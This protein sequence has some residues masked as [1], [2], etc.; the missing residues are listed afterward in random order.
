MEPTQIASD[1]CIRGQI[2]RSLSLQKSQ[3]NGSIEQPS[4]RLSKDI[5]EL[6]ASGLAGD[7]PFGGKKL[8]KL[9]T[10]QKKQHYGPEVGVSSLPG[11]HPLSISWSQSKLSSSSPTQ[12][13]RSVSPPR[14]KEEQH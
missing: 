2:Q 10:L 9:P 12:R 5:P 11:P 7:V 3:F 8:S 14:A 1:C 4:A 13:R 6:A